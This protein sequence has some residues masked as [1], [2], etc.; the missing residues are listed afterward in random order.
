MAKINK[1][2]ANKVE[3]RIE[4]PDVK[5]FGIV[6]YDFDNHYPQRVIDIIN[7]SPTASLCLRLYGKY[8]IG[9]GAVDKEFYSNKVNRKGLT[10]EQLH[11]KISKSIGRHKGV[12]IQVNYNIFG[13]KTEVNYVPFEYWRLPGEDA[14]AEEKD[15]YVLHEDWDVRKH[16][17]F[18]EKKIVRINKYDP[19]KV[20]EQVQLEEGETFEEKFKNY[21]GQLYV[22]TEE[23]A[24]EYPLSMFDPVLEDCI[25]EAQTKRF[26]NNTSAKNFLA[27]HI[28]ITGRTE[29][30]F[31]DNRRQTTTNAEDFG[32][33]L[34]EFQGGDGSGTIL[35]LELENP[36]E[37]V[38]LQKVD[39][40]DYDG[41]Y[42]YTEN[43]AMESIIGQFLIPPIL[44]LRGERSFGSSKEL[45]ESAEYYNGVTE[46]ERNLI[47]V[48]FKE[49]FTGFHYN[50][51]P[52][53]DYSILPIKVVAPIDIAYQ[54]Y[55][56]VNEFRV[57]QGYEAIEGDKSLFNKLGETKTKAIV[58][59]I[60]NTSL[61]VEQK[62]GVLRLVYGLGESDINDMV[63]VKTNPNIQ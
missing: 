60:A 43:S 62:K 53:G 31:D 56:S 2:T 45:S 32:R 16:K 61:D 41:L 55:F 19:T 9:R 42:E 40:Q 34:E 35:W 63:G 17:K 57:S 49:I 26:K 18:D 52:S 54:Q 51:C 7:D 48:I 38:K 58:D 59:L 44:I 47:S 30:E 23:G 20:L 22:W 3:K 1:A 39:I 10:V 21:K 14:K 8:L 6:G 24:N 25:T 46:D 13:E 4:L 50:I 15:K 33:N 12:A 5:K 27:S 28:L 11:R 29:E 37:E 36:E